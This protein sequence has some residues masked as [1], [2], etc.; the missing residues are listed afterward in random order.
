MGH[1]IGIE[2]GGTKFVMAHGTG[3][4]DLHDR[5]RIETQDP[6]TVMKQVIG[7][8]R[9]VEK[10]VPV[11]GIGASVFG[12][13]DINKKSD[14]YG[15]I[16]TTPKAGWQHFDFVGALKK[17]FNLPVGFDTDVNTTALGEY[18]WGAAQGLDDF[19]YIT[20][21][22]GIGA[23]GLLDGK[24]IHG[25]MHPEMGH[26][27]VPR[28]PDDPYK[29]VC[30][31]HHDCLEGLASG[32]SIME[33]WGVESALDLPADHQAWEIEAYY[34]GHA[35]ANYTL[36]LSP[37]KVIM[38]GGVMQQVQ[39]YQLIQY[40]ILSILSGY[41]KNRWIDDIENYVVPPGLGQDAGVCGA[42]VL[43][44]MA[45]DESLEHTS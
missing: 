3:P 19:I 38:G 26:I 23:G 32:P 28:H 12:P 43:A 41:I 9:Q 16:T 17:E 37:E 36:T 24:P 20:V 14:Q 18:R 4:D 42:F 7:Y 10:K 1:F 11:L 35:V 5:V 33:R 21:G 13:L 27:F 22:T 8:V 40:N 34:L 45:A 25:A 44:E 30:P 39:L 29:G 2:G 6:I 31:F 15:F